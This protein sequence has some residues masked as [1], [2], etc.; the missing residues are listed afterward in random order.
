M[1]S[2]VYK[3]SWASLTSIVSKNAYLHFSF[4]FWNTMVFP[5]PLFKEKRAELI[6]QLTNENYTS[7]AISAAFAKVG[8]E[9]NRLIEKGGRD[10]PIQ[11]LYERVLIDLGWT[12]KIDLPD[13]I[14]KVEQIF[15]QF[16]PTLCEDFLSFLNFLLPFE[17]T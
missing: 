13:L 5:N 12:G 8:E 3:G 14:H 6:S 10:L 4:D 11:Q 1:D 2:I 16:P 7:K 15:L 17:K 9:H